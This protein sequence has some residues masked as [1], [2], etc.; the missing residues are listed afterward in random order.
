MPG[1]VTHTIEDAVMSGSPESTMPDT[2]GINAFEIDTD[3]QTTLSSALSPELYSIA[4]PHLRELG[5]LVGTELDTLSRTADANPPR[6]RTFDSRGRLV[7][8]ID[9][10]PA[11]TRMEHLGVEQFGLV[12][13]SHKPVL[14]FDAPVPHV[15]K[16]AFWYLFVQAE[17][18]LACPMSM[19]DA[20]IRVLKRYGD[21]ALSERFV[22]PMLRTE[23]GH[24]SGAQFMTEKQ[25][26]S[27]VGA[28]VVE[29]RQDGG[30]WRLWGDKWFCS[31]VSAD[32]ALVLARPHGAAPGT[33]GLAMFLMPRLLPDGSMNSF[34]INR[35]K[36]KLGT[37]A[38]ASGEVQFAGALCYPVGEL[39]TG[40]K[41]MMSMVN[42]SRLSNAMRS[43]A[44]MRRSYIEALTSAQGRP[45]FGQMLVDKPLMRAAL[46]GMLVESEA[47][48]ATL[49]HTAVSYDRA[50]AA[51]ASLSPEERHASVPDEP[52][53][54]YV[55]LLTP[56]LKG[57]ICKRGRHVVSE[58]MEARGGNGYIDDWVDGKLLR[59]AQLGSIWEGT[60]NIVALDVQR[61]ML[62]NG[63]DVPFFAEI[64][65]KLTPYAVDTT[66]GR[67]AEYLLAAATEAEQECDQLSLLGSEHRELGAVRLM[68]RL[69][70]LLA[71][72]LLLEQ[73]M[74]EARDAN[75][76]RKLAVLL[77][78]LDEHFLRQENTAGSAEHVMLTHAAEQ[79]LSA[80]HVPL[81]AVEPMLLRT[82]ARAGSR[83][84]M[85]RARERQGGA[86]TAARISASG[87]I[88]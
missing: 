34:R 63:S 37:R 46:F 52:H 75:S 2:E 62:R 4:A 50:D 56:L 55:R 16:Y 3:L 26:G 33:S 10:H 32:L 54:R 30:E 14:G 28:N 73:A 78:Y 61:A 67:I 24:F 76:F 70:D 51:V 5:R 21:T 82:I 23:P 84:P 60:T 41:Q 42:A 45:A 1:F 57:V 86:A 83:H 25:G 19:T 80:G 64:R 6:L 81:S 7:N 85:H 44:L 47:A 38:M 71:S 20:A 22:E 49:F 40:F 87:D 17:F 43:A 11:Y 35:L 36:D 65:G 27:D 74:T 59:D 12:A 9:Y 88:K 18:A 53:S 15:L 31:N 13:M 79:V 29:A 48:A 58:G 68:H 66:V 8:A 72:S 77:G 69:Y 39:G